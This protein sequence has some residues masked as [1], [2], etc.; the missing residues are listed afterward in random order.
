MPIHSRLSQGAPIH[1]IFIHMCR[2][3][4]CHAKTLQSYIPPILYCRACSP[5]RSTGAQSLTTDILI[6]HHGRVVCPHS[7]P[8]QKTQQRKTVV[9]ECLEVCGQPRVSAV[10]LLNLSVSPKS[11]LLSSPFDCPAAYPR[12]METVDGRPKLMCV[13]CFGLEARG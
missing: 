9:S 11:I 13:E 2:V 12:N 4:A 3:L 10:S 8:V 6:A 7:H 5:S 1:N